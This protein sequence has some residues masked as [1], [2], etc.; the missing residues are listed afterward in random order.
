MFGGESVK[1]NDEKKRLDFP[2]SFD[3]EIVYYSV[4]KYI[5][6]FTKGLH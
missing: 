4:R 5:T 6:K 3:N 2:V 1:I